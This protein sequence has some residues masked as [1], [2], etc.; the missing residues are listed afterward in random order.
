VLNQKLELE[1]GQAKGMIHAQII[2][3]ML[4]SKSSLVVNFS[5]FRILDQNHFYDGNEVVAGYLHLY[6]LTKFYFLVNLSFF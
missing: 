3:Q 4:P 2:P 1:A 5:I 6:F